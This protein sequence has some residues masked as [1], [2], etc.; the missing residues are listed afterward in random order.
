MFGK[1][2]K[3]TPE[4][5]VDMLNGNQCKD[6][7]KR[8]R[9]AL[10][11][12]VEGILCPT[13]NSKTTKFRPEVVEMFGDIEE[14]KE[15]PWGRQSFFLTVRRA[16]A[17]V[18]YHYAEQESVALQGFAHAMTLVTIFSCPLIIGL[19]NVEDDREEEEEVSVEKV[20]DVLW[21][22]SWSSMYQMQRIL[23]REDRLSYLSTTIIVQ[24]YII[25]VS[26]SV[27]ILY[28][29]LYST[30]CMCY[31]TFYTIFL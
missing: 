22:R 10:L 15:F 4:S 8:F 5:I 20:L 27:T 24:L 11:L 28:C 9:L 7:L 16:K 31:T 13:S 14:F 17:K 18:P 30:F 1:S 23:I 29:V 3:P 12:V 6:P 25:V 19:T 21:I 26:S 2:K